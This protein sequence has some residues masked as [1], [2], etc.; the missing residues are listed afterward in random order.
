MMHR[1]RT[2]WALLALTGCA[3][4]E[5]AIGAGQVGVAA[6][7]DHVDGAVSDAQAMPP[8]TPPP[9]PTPPPMGRGA[10]TTRGI[11]ISREE[12]RAQAHVA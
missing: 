6:C 4:P 7:V 11:W 9:T 8:P 10:A 3:A 5:A 1:T 2:T 12:V